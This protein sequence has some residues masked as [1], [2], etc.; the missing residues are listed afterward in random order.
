MKVTSVIFVHGFAGSNR[1]WQSTSA[2]LLWPR[3][4]LP[5]TLPEARIALFSYDSRPGTGAYEE[6]QDVASKF[7]RSLMGLRRFGTVSQ[8]A[9]EELW[10]KLNAF[11]CDV[12]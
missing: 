8:A 6:L 7:M 3:E 10:L 4:L 2:G 12:R 5:R 9:I 11:R 1:T